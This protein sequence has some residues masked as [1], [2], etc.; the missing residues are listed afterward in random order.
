MLDAQFE[1]LQ[2]ALADRYRFR[3]ELGRGGWGVVYLAEDLK[4][5]R[6][7][8]IKVLRPEVGV[9]PAHDRFLREIGIAARLTHP[10]IV[11][12]FDSGEA[13]GLLFYV[14]PFIDGETLQQRLRRERMLAITDAVGIAREVAGALA[15]AH[16][17]GVIHRDVKPANILLSGG[18]ALV[19][20]FGIARAIG[21][22]S[23]EAGISSGGI[24]VGTPEYMSP[25]QASGDTEVDGRS[26]LY[27]LACI[28]YEMLAATPPF[29]APTALG[30]IARHSLD[31]V[32]PLRTLRPGVPEHLEQAISRALAKVPADRF[33]DAEA[34][35]Q[36]LA[37][38]I[39]VGPTPVARRKVSSRVAAGLLVV[40]LAAGAFAGWRALRRPPTPALRNWVLVSDFAV[41]E[42][43]RSLGVAVRELVAAGLNQSPALSV[44]P[45]EQVRL[46]MRDA[47][48]PDAVALDST[49]AREIA[50]RTSVRVIITGRISRV[51]RDAYSIVLHAVDAETGE[52]RYSGNTAAPEAGGEMIERVERLVH[53]LR[54]RLGERP[55]VVEATRP[56]M[57]ARTPSF[58]A[59]RRYAD[60][61]MAMRAG[62]YDRSNELLQE[63]VQIDSAFATAWAAMA[64]NYVTA[65]RP[66]SARAAFA[67]ALAFPERMSEADQHRLRGDVAFHVEGDLAAAVRA[68]DR[69]LIDEPASVGGLNNRG[70]YLSGIG[71]HE[72][73][74]RDFEVAA[75][76]DPLRKG[77]R[78]IQLMN[79]AGELVVLGRLDS[80]RA[81]A[82]RLSGAP[83]QYLELLLLN[84]SNDWRTLETRARAHLD[85]PGLE[86]FVRLPAQT[87]AIG[88]LAAMGAVEAAADSLRHLMGLA[89]GAEVRWFA[90]ALLLLDR[91]LERR[92]RWPLPP[93]VVRDTSTG[94][95]LLRGTHAAARGDTA[96]AR[97]ALRELTR[98]G[99][100]ADRAVGAGREYLAALLEGEQGMWPQAA[101]RLAT[102]ARR[103]EHDP[104]SLDRVGSLA[105][106]WFAAVA[107][108]R[109]GMLDSATSLLE[110]VVEPRG[111]PP[112][113]YA[114][115]GLVVPP[116]RRQLAQWYMT[117]GNGARSAEHWRAFR[118]AVVSPDSITQL[119]LGTPPRGR[120]GS[121]P[122]S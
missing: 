117:L 106:R 12:L 118:E 70:L 11:P 78:Q 116:A 52:N 53:D 33:P 107:S 42:G 79:I 77:P 7:V 51:G 111:M 41:P 30:V 104:F 96:A 23:P 15:H 22:D 81:T 50:F 55:A 46:A 54:S 88:A 43:E 61:M 108:A 114:L 26:D 19:A 83:A 10:H 29:S 71:R 6:Q 63:A 67:R 72:E 44:V 86:R 74:L 31:P 92:P 112:G 20:D 5:H 66:D 45:E 115:R 49:V 34:F 18:H 8:A 59:F 100:A 85:D 64:M 65:R 47:A 113:H 82:R 122:P 89:E 17:Q 28:L 97:T 24:R 4:H 32:P 57:H 21:A 14:M 39:S 90:N 1:P 84:A 60:G 2:S 16:A 58:T 62:T 99:E 94:S 120:E 40:A 36:A 109:A 9:L 103:G 91:A 93:A 80:A 101:A 68:Y 110:L 75:T 56:L 87:H 73:A 48:L 3:R 38:P 13:A 69:Y 27:S 102:I 25:E 105:L 121:L 37:S 95:V 98:R 76:I 119:W 35:Q